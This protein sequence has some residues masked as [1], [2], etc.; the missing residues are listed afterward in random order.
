MADGK[1]RMKKTCGV[2][3]LV[4]FST[5]PTIADNF[6]CPEEI[7]SFLFFHLPKKNKRKIFPLEIK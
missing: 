1:I 4:F 6:F 5:D 3:F 2:N 7:F